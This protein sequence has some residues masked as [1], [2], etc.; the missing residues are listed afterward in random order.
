MLLDPRVLR[1]MQQDFSDTGVVPRFARD[2]STSLGDK[3][4][5]LDLRVR[6]GDT[7]GARDAAI[8]LSISADM[9]GAGRLRD[10]ARAARTS[11]GA[12]ASADSAAVELLRA[13]AAD[14]LR[15]LELTYPGSV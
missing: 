1:D 10:A 5:R 11:L 12:D 3:L 9:I 7:T 13:C 2:F 14:T 4:D 8:S 6:D 15:Q